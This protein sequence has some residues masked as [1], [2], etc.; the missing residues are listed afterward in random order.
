M[1]AAIFTA[2]T[3]TFCMY[4]RLFLPAEV[5]TIRKCVFLIYTEIWMRL[6]FICTNSIIN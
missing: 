1:L 3:E 6:T 5:T 4:Y 2:A